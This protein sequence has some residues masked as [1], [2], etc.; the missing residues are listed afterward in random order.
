MFDEKAQLHT[1]EGV[2]AATILLLVIIYAI[3]ATSMTP[4]TSSTSNVYME[5][6]LRE[7]GQDILN[8]MD[9]TEPGYNSKL[10]N[11]IITWDGYES[12]WNG[13][14]YVMMNGGT[15]SLTNNMSVTLNNTLIRQGIAHNVEIIFLD[16]NTLTLNNK[17]IIH[18]GDPSYSAVVVSRKIVLQDTES[19]PNPSN[20]IRD[21]DPSTNLYNIVEV[22]LVLW[23]T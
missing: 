17:K 18:N 6:E 14:S 15:G 12:T 19:P 1:L 22:K 9:Y 23:R 2:A 21:I 7:L 4:L 11:D 13:S 8:T 10:K 5:S 16:N 3:D 20:P